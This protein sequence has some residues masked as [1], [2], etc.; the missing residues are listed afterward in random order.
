ML[1]KKIS[2]ALGG[3]IIV[4]GLVLSLDHTQNPN[5]VQNQSLRSKIEAK[6]K[7]KK[8]RTFSGAMEMPNSK[9]LDKQ[10][11][12]IKD[13]LANPNTGVIPE[14]M[15]SRELE[16]ASNLP[17]MQMAVDFE[18]RG[19]YNVGG[20]TRAFAVDVNDDQTL[21]AG[22]ISGGIW[23]ST[24]G[25]TS[26]TK[27]TESSVFGSVTCLVQDKRPGKTNI[28]YY[29]TGEGYGNSASANGAYFF[30]NGMFKSEDNGETWQSLASTTSSSST[31][32]LESWQ[33][34][35][36]VEIDHTVDSL[37]IVYGATHGGISRS[38]DGGDTWTEILGT[39][40]SPYTTNIKVG[41][42]GRTYAFLNSD[43]SDA[44][45]G[46]WVSDDHGDTWTNI[47]PSNFPSTY[48]RGVLDIN[49]SNNNEVYFFMN[50]PNNGKHTNT[51]FDGEDWNSLW[52][53]TYD[54]TTTGTLG[55][56]TDLSD[57][58]PDSGTSFATLYTQSGYDMAIKVHPTQ[59]NVIYIGGTNIYRSDDGFTSNTNTHFLGGY[60]ENSVDTNW[61]ITANHHPDQHLI[62]FAEG[63]TTKLYSINDGGIFVSESPLDNNANWQSLNNGYYT[64]QLYAVSV[65]QNQVTDAIVGGFQDNGNFVTRES[66]T[67]APW[68]LPYNGDGS[69][70]YI[71]ENEENFYLSIQRGRVGKFTLD[72][73]GNKV[74]FRRID[75]A[76]IDRDNVGF[77]HPF[78]VDPNNE[79]FMY[80]PVKDTLYR[81]SQ[82]SS[83]VENE[84]LSPL[85]Q[86]WDYIADGFNIPANREITSLH[87]TKSNPEHT[88]Y[89][90]TN[91]RKTYKVEN[92]TSA[93]P[94][95]TELG[96]KDANGVAAYSAGYTS[97]IT[98]NPDNG[99]EIILVNSNYGTRS[100]A[101]SIDGGVTWNDISGNLEENPNGSG[102]GP[103]TRWASIMSLNSGEKL[104]LVGTS[105][106]LYGTIGVNGANTVWS[107][108]SPDVIGNVV[109][110][111][112]ITRKQDGLVLVATHG[113]GIFTANITSVF[114]LLN[115]VEND[116]Q[117]QL[118]ILQNPIVNNQ[119]VFE[120]KGEGKN[121]TMELIEVSTG[122]L[123]E[124]YKLNLT[125]GKQS[126]P[127]NVSSNVYIARFIVEDKI[128]VKKLS[129][130]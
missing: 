25:G 58:L 85:A 30:G 26:W 12:L 73:D 130:L 98:A 22:G 7:K 109:V 119:I 31:A 3:I 27:K 66:N 5:Q 53:Y 63:D 127:I 46:V 11:E 35:W 21:I 129:I 78:V 102:D 120:W 48:E 24:N 65:N 115:T 15:R 86:G 18:H 2:I 55:V 51:F 61:D 19:P 43:A 6:K 37:D 4:S 99:N 49:L 62:V 29:G 34:M 42:N 112:V 60:A 20:R 123:I 122:K 74:S 10:Q 39:S 56:W 87:I 75:P 13:K 105:V 82:L 23:K 83:I 97:C 126:L 17:K 76:G 36:N 33:I 38:T 84:S 70:S 80:Y 93:T 106:G 91:H 121:A 128:V 107:Q 103:S 89:L 111:Q 57:N 69:F 92:A 41:D 117:E 100:L 110:E 28:W 104:Y 116:S 96:F 44:E 8:T 118:N 45:K 54:G 79:D 95:V 9:D 59:S 40:S 90:G 101:H 94:T 47:T 108:I 113:N 16:F 72:A 81:Q 77:I 124:R 1:T 114:D 50:T 52:K 67:A 14:N 71:A 125:Q 64:T 88:V 32:F 68:V